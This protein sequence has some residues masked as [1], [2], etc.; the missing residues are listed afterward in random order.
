[1]GHDYHQSR[2][3]TLARRLKLMSFISVFYLL[4]LILTTTV[5]YLLPTKLR[6]VWLLLAGYFFYLTWQP[7]FLVV[8]FCVSLL[9]YLFGKKIGATADRE[10]KRNWLIGSVIVL[11][12]PLVFFKYYNFLNENLA[13]LLGGFAP[14]SRLPNQPFLIPLGISFFTFQAVSY[15]ADIYRGYLKPEPAIEK[16][17]L[18]IAFFPTLLAGPIERAKSILGQLSRPAN[19]EYENIRAGLQLILWGVF[20]KVVIAD[21]LGDFIKNVYAEPESFQGIL[22]YFAAIL[23]IFQLFCDFSA[24]SDI[25]VGSA[26][27]LGIRLS[28]NFDDRVYAA[29]SR[30]IFW[31]GWHR[32]LT[33]WLR[34]YVFF[35]LSRRVKNKFHLYLNLLF[36][37]L[38]VGIWHGAAWGFII[39]GL[40][41]GVWLVLEGV[42]KT[43]RRDFYASAGVDTNGRLF[44]FFAWLFS[45]HVGAFFGL[46]FRAD[47]M[48]QAFALLGNVLNSNANL[49][50]RLETRNLL[51]SIG[52]LVL[53]DLINRRI[54]K[55]ENFDAFIGRQKAWFRWLIYIVLAQL[56]LRY[57]FVFDNA[58]FMYFNF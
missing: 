6:N 41:N 48:Q 15:V 38:L 4:F 25:A 55:N 36:V 58:N 44:Y 42:T 7:A 11:F 9:S 19:F 37:Y 17:A 50:A 52:S 54:P 47:T 33:S 53:M 35:P 18:Y 57:L 20:K 23:A 2:V 16:Y 5:F 31:Q 45:L 39:W 12:L 26:R 32:S 14:V 29:P 8:L 22:V 51:M 49:T 28:K 21:R 40:L 24:Y 43:R 46:F 27:L 10:R 56:I 1:M 30:E 3:K 34:D 13:N